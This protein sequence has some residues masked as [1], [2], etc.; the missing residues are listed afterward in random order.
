[1]GFLVITGTGGDGGGNFDCCFSGFG[2]RGGGT[3]GTGGGGLA[4]SSSNFI[5]SFAWNII[6]VR[7]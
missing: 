3:D 6:N 2:G 5:K 1:M 4:G 7:S